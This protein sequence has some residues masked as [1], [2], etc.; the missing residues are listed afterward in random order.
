[1]VWKYKQ[2]STV[3]VNF[4]NIMGQMTEM[5]QWKKHKLDRS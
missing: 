2:V 4:N 3:T 5:C 1:M